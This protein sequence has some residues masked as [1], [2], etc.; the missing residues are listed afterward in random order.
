ME[1]IKDKTE[2]KDVYIT[3][4]NGITQASFDTVFSIIMMFG[5]IIGASL[6]YNQGNW[7]HFVLSVVGVIYFVVLHNKAYKK[8][9]K[10]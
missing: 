4:N 10:Q 1:E 9:P 5:F 7:F 6:S 2:T 3:V 8:L